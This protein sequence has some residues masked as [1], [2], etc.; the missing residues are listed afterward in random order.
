MAQEPKYATI[1]VGTDGSSR[2]AQAVEQ[3]ATLAK[4]YRST[5]HV[6]HAYQGTQGPVVRRAKQVAD[7]VRDD[8]SDRGLD[9]QTHTMLGHP[10]DAL[11][12][13]AFTCDADLI[14]VGNRGMSGRG[15][16]LGSVPNAITHSA[17]CAVLIVPTSD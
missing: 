14:V 7:R 12:D 17:R 9:I 4:A 8:L 16:I 15:R 13:L 1:V 11:L 2:A 10:A 6:V 3:A 5:L